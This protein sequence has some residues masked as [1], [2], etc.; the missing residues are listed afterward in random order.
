MKRFK[1]VQSDADIVSH[2]GLSLI[3]QCVHR[4][5]NLTR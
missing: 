3:G 1:I 2:G 5:T 4:H